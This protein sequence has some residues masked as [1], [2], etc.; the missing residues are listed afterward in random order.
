[1]NA[2]NIYMR[3]NSKHGFI[4]WEV[5]TGGNHEITQIKAYEQGKGYGKQLMQTYLDTASPPFY[6]VYAFVLASREKARTFY[7]SCGFQEINL[8]RSIYRDDKT[9]LVWRKFS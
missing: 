9:I 3:I 5:G 2:C 4:E 1:M 6:S 8:G 7:K